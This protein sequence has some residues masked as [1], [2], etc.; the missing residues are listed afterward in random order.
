MD[1]SILALAGELNKVQAYYTLDEYNIAGC[2]Y[3][4]LK[5]NV[6]EHHMLTT[7]CDLT[8]NTIINLFG[9]IR[10]DIISEMTD[11][12]IIG[13]SDELDNNHTF[14][15]SGGYIYHSYATE[16]PLKCVEIDKSIV[17][18]RLNKLSTF[19]TADNWEEVTGVRPDYF[20]DKCVITLINLTKCDPI[21]SKT[22]AIILINNALQALAFSGGKHQD[23][24]YTYILSLDRL[25]GNN[26]INAIEYLNNLLFKITHC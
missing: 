6:D 13:M 7:R 2:N 9:A 24:G 5:L 14:V 21:Q 8:V 4:A 15:Y 11:N 23:E 3:F 26:I 19:P 18:D 1:D 12:C 22:N 16:Y 10:G 25:D 20:A 17:S